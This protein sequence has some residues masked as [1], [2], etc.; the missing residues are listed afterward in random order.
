MLE[1][2]VVSGAVALIVQMGAEW[3]DI[4]APF[5]FWSMF[6]VAVLSITAPFAQP[7]MAC[8]GGI[9]FWIALHGGSRDVLGIWEQQPLGSTFLKNF[10]K[11]WEC[12]CLISV[13]EDVFRR[14]NFSS[15]RQVLNEDPWIFD[16][17]T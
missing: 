7:V 5:V 11:I 15:Q 6:K 16:E 13:L 2:A 10:S 9:A 4:R 3:E 12:S 14:F 1:H 17:E 8:W